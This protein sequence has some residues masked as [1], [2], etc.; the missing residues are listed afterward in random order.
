MLREMLRDVLVAAS[1]ALLAGGGGGSGD[2]G[3]D[4]GGNGG[5]GNGGGGGGEGGIGD[6]SACTSMQL[7]GGDVVSRQYSLLLKTTDPMQLLGG[8]VVSSQYYLLRLA[9]CSFLVATW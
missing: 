8:D 3:A 4:A 2:G 6:G 7:L 1:P 5:G 9:R